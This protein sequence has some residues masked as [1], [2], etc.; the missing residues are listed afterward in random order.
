MH[1]PENAN[2]EIGVRGSCASSHLEVL[3]AHERLGAQACVQC[4]LNDFSFR[5]ELL[6]GLTA[7]EKNYH[8]H[9]LVSKAPGSVGCCR[10]DV[11]VQRRAYLYPGQKMGRNQL[12]RAEVSEDS[13]GLDEKQS[14]HARPVMMS[15]AALGTLA[16]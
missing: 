1:R 13:G 11:R 2:S 14:Q 16:Q 4:V 10:A 8:F 7:C 12:C 5:N 6:V 9:F 15:A 3:D